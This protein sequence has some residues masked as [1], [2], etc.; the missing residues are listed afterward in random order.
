M[1]SFR[2]VFLVSLNC[3]VAINSEYI[4]LTSSK[5]KEKNVVINIKLLPWSS[6]V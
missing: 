3:R 6:L 4:I 2:V 1:R 5:I